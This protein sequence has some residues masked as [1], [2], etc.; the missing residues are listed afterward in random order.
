MAAP[1][2]PNETPDPGES[3]A[4]LKPEDQTRR[5]TG[6][7]GFTIIWIGQLVSLL[8]TGM[9]QFALTIWAW[10][11]TGEATALALVAFFTAVPQILTSPLAGAIVDRHDR[12]HVMMLSDLAAGIATAAVLLLH[13]S[14]NLQVWHLYI[15]GAFT[16]AFSAFQ[17]PA[18]SAA[19]STML[20]KEQYGRASG[21]ISLAEA[22]SGII[23]PIAAGILLGVV[24]IGGIMAFDIITF[25]VAIGTLLVIYI[26]KPMSTGLEGDKPRSIWE[27][28]I[29]GFR[30]IFERPSL[31]GLL[32]VFLSINFILS[33]S[34][35]LFA[36]MILA[37]TGDNTMVLGSVQSAFGVGGI[38]GGLLMSAWGGPKRR[39]H[40]V[41]LGC[42]ITSLGT[43]L[44]GIGRGLTVWA[45][46]AFA[47]MIIIPILNGSSQAIWQTK[48]PPQIQGRVFATRALLARIAQPLGMAVTG[49]L[50]DLIFEPA[51]MPGGRLA[52]MFGWLVGTGPGAGMAL[53]FV[54]MGII[55]TL[56]CLMGYAF[57]AV[58][59]MEDI[60]PD[61]DMI[62]GNGDEEPPQEQ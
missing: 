24:G 30:Y 26:P 35:T 53:V 25:I 49:P 22:A 46:A 5:P 50:A 58:R 37:R 16:G 1:E 57:D 29:Y 27:D 62:Q 31:V 8:G 45:A 42:A 7:R 59:N 52:P 38:L 23:A 34:F 44:F 41:L 10:Q 14:G 9:T 19:V 48:I 36:P 47:I 3:G 20:P 4:T 13:T 61:Y 32:A 6:M 21:M 56:P 15:T 11:T 55:G 12:K 39:I 17:F 28:S 51:M 2:S 54:F 60:L 43:C 18:Y 33:F 40:A